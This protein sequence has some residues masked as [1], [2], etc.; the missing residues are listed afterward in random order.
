[1]DDPVPHTRLAATVTHAGLGAD[2][3][4]Q[5]AP[6]SDLPALGV[7]WTGP[8]AH[9]AARGLIASLLSAGGPW[10][11][12]AEATLITTRQTLTG[13]LPDTD[14]LN[15]DVDPMRLQTTD[16][17]DQALSELERHLL[18]R[19]RLAADPELARDDID[20]PDTG[21]PDLPPLVLLA[22]A[23][24]GGTATRLAA[25]LTVGSRLAITA[26]L[27]GDWPTGDTWHVGPDGTP[28][29]PGQDTT[30]G[31]RLN[32]LD[33]DTAAQ[34]LDTVRQAHPG[35]PDPQTTPPPMPAQFA[36]RAAPVP[37]AF[38]TGAPAVERAPIP[39][40]LLSHNGA[41][42]GTRPGLQLAV[43]GRPRVRV[44]TG[45]N[46][47]DLRI[48]R[49]DGV[50]LLVHFAVEPAGATSDELMALLWPQT[51]PQ[52]S[53]RRFHTTL[54]ELRHTLTDA[55]GADPVSRTQDRYHL[56]P[57]LI[58]VDLWHLHAAVDRAATAVDPAHQQAA[59][60]EVIRRYTG[61]VA[62]GHT[63]LWLD[64]HRE[65]VRRHVLTPTPLSPKRNRPPR[66]TGHHPDAIRADP[67]TRTCTSGSE[68][69]RR[70]WQF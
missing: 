57:A 60:Q 39:S 55:V 4:G 9:D 29:I 33:E 66:R 61:P 41:A 59:L 3:T 21:E 56:D 16:T 2:T 52:H 10:S 27:L 22:A 53:R 14:G 37:G 28:T 31:P 32:M 46:S 34:I 11:P 6:L 50:A 54:S 26:V 17:L 24:T 1:M 18:R 20:D 15:L 67:S 58:D 64:P 19:A 35:D 62:E 44:T 7:G 47:G 69:A 8:G 13:L 70:S 30:C 25:I 63:W 38:G 42:S 45:T 48:R 49:S 36:A 5:T 12:A 40:K 51:R 43:L 65:A 68:P 23:P